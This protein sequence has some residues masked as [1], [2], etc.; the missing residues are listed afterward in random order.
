[1]SARTEAAQRHL[2]GLR[3]RYLAR[4]TAAT[5]AAYLRAKATIFGHPKP[6]PAT[7]LSQRGV[8]FI[9]GFEGFVDHVYRDA[10]GIPTIGFGHVVRNGEHFATI[11]RA[12]GLQL[13]ADDAHLATAAVLIATRPRSLSQ[14]QLDALTS[15]VYNVG[16]GAFRSSTLL[17]KLN[18]GDS[19]GAA[20]EF[21]KWDRAG[22]RELAGLK[23]R[24]LAERRL[25]LS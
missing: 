3:R 6:A 20:D 8:E 5:R 14:G 10:V 16:A 11:T 13:L 18:A 12:Q 23:T 24:R 2:Q 22:G 25:F 21:L 15:F 17:R 9:A 1:M 4:P 7:R 19:K